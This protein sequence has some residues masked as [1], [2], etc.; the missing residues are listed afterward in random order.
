MREGCGAQ[1]HSAMNPLLTLLTA[2]LFAPRGELHAADRT[3]P[4]AHGAIGA[5]VQDHVLVDETPGVRGHRT[6]AGEPT[7]Q[8]FSQLA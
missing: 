4:P 6:S 1:K 8:A 2:L 3:M 5:L 7:R